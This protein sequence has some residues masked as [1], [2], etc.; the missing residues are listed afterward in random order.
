MRR[1]VALEIGFGLCQIADIVRPAGASAV[2]AAA[3]AERRF[4]NVQIAALAANHD[5]VAGVFQH[6]ALHSRVRVRA[7]FLPRVGFV[8]SA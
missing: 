1:D 6:A 2:L 7:R 4:D 5:M 8:A 3:G